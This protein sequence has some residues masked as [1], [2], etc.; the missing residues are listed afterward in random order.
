MASAPERWFLPHFHDTGSCIG[1]EAEMP[2]LRASLRARPARL[3][4]I[5]RLVTVDVRDGRDVEVVPRQRLA[6]EGIKVAAQVVGDRPVA[7]RVGDRLAADGFGQVVRMP[8]PGFE[9]EGG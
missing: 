1:C 7:A 2:D 8:R 3:R 9:V 4:A 5:L 6:A